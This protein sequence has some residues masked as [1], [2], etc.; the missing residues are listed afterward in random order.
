MAAS[1]LKTKNDSWKAKKKKEKKSDLRAHFFDN[2]Y[3]I[4]HLLDKEHEKVV[5]C[6]DS[7]QL[8]GSIDN[9]DSPEFFSLSSVLG[10]RTARY[11]H[12]VLQDFLSSP[13]RRESLPPFCS[14]NNPENNVPIGHNFYRLFFVGDCHASHIVLF[15]ELDGLKDRR[16]R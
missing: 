16:F 11:H 3:E 15:H 4:G 13:L 8:P 2:T 10:H 9:R 6:D 5:N 12:A 1:L 7:S 14:G